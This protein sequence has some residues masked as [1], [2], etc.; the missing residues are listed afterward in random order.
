M[1]QQTTKQKNDQDAAL[2]QKEIDQKDRHKTWELNNAKEIER[3]RLQ[4]KAGD[5][6]AK[7]QVQGQKAQE[8]REAHQAHML[9]NQQKMAIDR[10]KF[11]LQVGQHNLKQQDTAQRSNERQMAAQQKAQQNAFGGAP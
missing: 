6:D 1:K 5:D 10:E 8:S 4:A 7:L 2:K 3:I 9:E 11:N